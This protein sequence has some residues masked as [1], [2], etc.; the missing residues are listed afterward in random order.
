MGYYDWLNNNV[1]DYT[2][3]IVV[4]TGANSGVGLACCKVFAYR[5]AHVILACRNID[6]GNLAA[7][8]IRKDNPKAILNVERLDVASLESIREFV[9]MIKTKYH[10]IDVLVNNAGIYYVPLSYTV[11]GFEKCMG[12]NYIGAYALTIQLLPLI[13]KGGKVVME[14]SVVH[15]LAKLNYNDFYSIKHYG[16]NNSYARSKLAIATFGTYLSKYLSEINYGVELNV[17]HPGVTATK[18]ISPKK[19]GYNVI[20]SKLG[21][22]FL[23]LFTHRP[24]VACLCLVLACQNH[25]DS[26]YTYGPRGL[27]H[28][29]GYPTIHELSKKVNQ[30]HKELIDLTEKDSKIKIA[31]YVN[32][33]N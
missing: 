16:K 31:D 12:T 2:G 33:Q 28:I 21:N 23:T 14:T 25:V 27:L 32:T 30:H 24:R 1:Q 26:G 29:S 3:K 19:G 8:E 13:K 7:N 5:N 22:I 15:S 11:D 9:E 18:I 17:S 20:I 6:K 4:V 10:Q